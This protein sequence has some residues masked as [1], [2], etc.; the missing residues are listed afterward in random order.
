MINSP[1]WSVFSIIVKKDLPGLLILQVKGEKKKLNILRKE[2]GNHRYQRV[3]PTEKRGRVH[4][5]SV[6]VAVLEDERN[7]DFELDM[8]DVEFRMYKASGKGGQHRNKTESAVE[9]THIPTGITAKCDSERSQTD[10]KRIATDLLNQKLQEMYSS[11]YKNKRAEKRRDQV[12][13]GL[14]GDK[15]QTVQEQNDR[16]VNHVSGKKISCKLYFKGR[17]DLLHEKG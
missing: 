11:Q 16:V 6:T 9:V 4:T 14:R 10:N 13:T 7:I 2:T 12:G 5:S 3:P 8:N 17:I 1:K 15:V